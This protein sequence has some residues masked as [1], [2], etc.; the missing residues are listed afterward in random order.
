MTKIRIETDTMGEMEVPSE[1]YWGA[2]TQ[3]SLKYFNIGDQKMP[4]VLIKSLAI[5]KLCAADVNNKLGLLDNTK[6]TEIKKVAQDIVDDKLSDNFPLS[7]WQTGSGTQTNMN[8]NEVISNKAIENLG[9]IVGSKKPIHPN[10]DVNMG[11][12]SNDVFPTAMNI[13]T[14]LAT[15]EKLLPALDNIKK[16]LHNKE[17][18]F[19]DIIKIGR[20]HMQDATPLTLGQEF[21]GYVAQVQ[22]C[23]AMIKQS[24]EQIFFLAQGGTAVGTGINTHK[25]FATKFASAVADYTNLPFESAP[26]KF[27]SLASHDDLVNFSGSLNALAVALNKIANDVRLMACGPRAGI[28]ELSLPENEPGSSIMPGKVNPTQVEALTMVCCQVM[29][30]NFAVS[31]G[32]MNGHLELNVYKPLIIHNILQSI[33]LLSDAMNSFVEHCLDGIVPNTARINDL[34]QN[35]LMLVTA[36]NKHIGYDNAA[37]IAKHAHKNNLTLK[38]SALE[39][40]LVSAQDFDAWVQ[41]KAMV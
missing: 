13:A 22:R 20:T 41:P 37:K 26:N 33:D 5:V 2:Q 23:E 27:A 29:G 21:S 19:K 25:E 30:N 38:Q 9:G 6:T 15:V 36:L 31:L 4:K 14:V 28:G 16:S 7:I 32:G 17:Q 1:K 12:S 40:K 3:R 18:E 35:S 39:L 10:D 34:M 11:Q 8:V 24:L